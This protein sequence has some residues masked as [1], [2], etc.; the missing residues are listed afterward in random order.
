MRWIKSWL[1]SRVREDENWAQTL[2]RVTGNFFRI[3]ISLVLFGILTGLVVWY[4]HETRPFDQRHNVFVEV[5]HKKDA[6]DENGKTICDES[7][8]LFMGVENNS[9]KT[10]ERISANLTARRRGTARNLLAYNE[11]LT[12]AVLIPP[13]HSIGYCFPAPKV[14]SY[15]RAPSNPDDLMYSGEVD[16]DRMKLVE[17]EKWMIEETPAFPLD[18]D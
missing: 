10:V 4:W 5:F 3:S 16:F 17:T 13:N 7:L 12:I 8:P 18:M 11:D 1:W 9:S 15:H 6:P 2:I 14:A